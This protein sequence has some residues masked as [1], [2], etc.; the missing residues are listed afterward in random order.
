M[1]SIVTFLKIETARTSKVSKF[2][3]DYKLIQKKAVIFIVPAWFQSFS[4]NKHRN[5]KTYKTYLIFQTADKYVIN[6]KKCNVRK[7]FRDFDGEMT[8]NAGKLI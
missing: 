4:C 2:I 6:Y 7:K 8:F 3:A 5:N 1:L